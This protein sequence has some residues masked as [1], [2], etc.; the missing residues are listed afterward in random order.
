MKH[1]GIKSEIKAEIYRQYSSVVDFLE[2]NPELNVSES[3]ICQRLDPT[4]GCNLTKLMPIVSA[5]K[6]Q[7]ALK[8]G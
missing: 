6:M 8:R 2:K 7:L 3:G 4:R 1:F 5:L